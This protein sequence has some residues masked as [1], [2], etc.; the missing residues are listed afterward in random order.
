MWVESGSMEMPGWQFS[1]FSWLEKPCAG[2]RV[3]RVEDALSDLEMLLCSSIHLRCL[4][5]RKVGGRYT[6]CINTTTCADDYGRASSCFSSPRRPSAPMAVVLPLLSPFLF[7]FLFLFFLP[8]TLASFI[9]DPVTAKAATCEPV[10]LQWQGGKAPWTLH[11][12]ARRVHPR[13]PRDFQGTSFHWT[14][15]LDAGTVVAA[16][17]TDAAGATATSNSFTIQDGTTGCN[18]FVAVP[19]P[20]GTTASVPTETQGTASTGSVPSE[21]QAST[22]SSDPPAS[23]ARAAASVARAAASATR[24]AGASSARWRIVLFEPWTLNNIGSQYGLPKLGETHR[25]RSAS[26]NQ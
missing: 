12:R 19:P 10:P 21:T 25:H 18:Q 23:A 6:P 3:G 17:L 11:R 22:V 14:V 7:P 5:T 2:I 15:D 26:H 4:I 8:P 20:Q 13:E 9:V 1:I 16:R 24:V